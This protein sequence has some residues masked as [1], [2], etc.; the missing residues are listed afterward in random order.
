MLPENS[1]IQTV[2]VTKLQ[3]QTS[4]T[5]YLDKENKRITG[6]LND[7]LKAVEQAVYLRLSTERFDYAMF[8][9]GYGFEKKDLFG[10]IKEYVIPHAIDRITQSLL[11]DDRIN[12]VKDFTYVINKGD[13]L[14]NFTVVTKYG[15]M[16]IEGVGTNVWGYE[17]RKYIKEGSK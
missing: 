5:Y 14:L 13:Y 3:E 17:L 9:W 11:K 6:V 10:K 4:R 8:S 7:Y 16:R 1:G 2:S 12:E 15:D